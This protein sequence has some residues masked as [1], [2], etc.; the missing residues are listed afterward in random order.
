MAEEIIKKGSW[1][2]IH[3]IVLQP[4]ERADN[5]PEDTKQVPLELWVKG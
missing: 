5:V 2:Q 1:V 3:Y 4:S